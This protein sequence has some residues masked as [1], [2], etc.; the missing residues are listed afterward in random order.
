VSVARGVRA[1]CSAIVLCWSTLLVAGAIGSSARSAQPT[2]RTD[3]VAAAGTFVA[4][5]VVRHVASADAPT[6][7]TP[8]PAML[9]AEP[10]TRMRELGSELLSAPRATSRVRLGTRT[11]RGYD[12]AA[13]PAAA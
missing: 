8:W 3:V 2:L 6:W 4:P 10:A 12:A 9:A 13:P 7:R 11:L 5:V 1:L